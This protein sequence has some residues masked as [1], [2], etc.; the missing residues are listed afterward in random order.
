MHGHV[1]RWHFRKIIARGQEQ[2]ELHRLV[3]S[4]D[5]YRGEMITRI[6]HALGLQVR[7]RPRHSPSDEAARALLTRPNAL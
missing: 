2:Q 3:I 1:T 5:G 6:A 4:W 7:S